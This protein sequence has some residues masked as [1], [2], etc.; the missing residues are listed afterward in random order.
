MKYKHLSKI[1]LLIVCSSVTIK[2]VSAEPKAPKANPYKEE[3][4]VRHSLFREKDSLERM[5]AYTEG[6][7]AY[8]EEKKTKEKM[9]DPE[10]LVARKIVD[11]Y[12]KM[13]DYLDVNP[14]DDQL[15]ADELSEAFKDFSWPKNDP[16]ANDDVEYAKTLIT[17]YDTESK[18]SI[19]FLEFC[20]LMEEMWGAADQIQES[21]CG[22]AFDKSRE[23]FDKLFTWLDRD[24]DNL[25]TP[26]DMIY[27]ISRI[28]IRDVDMKEVQ[29]V[30]AKYDTK[31]T[32]KIDKDTFF[33]AIANG[34]LDETFFD[35]TQTN[36]FIK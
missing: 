13:F 6:V 30:F 1:L 2:M 5:S 29:E 20:K 27:G 4:K 22:N 16:D 17:K 21:K 34:G 15:S 23:I 8:P 3:K 33:L 32:G 10:E 26:E 18:G 31:K 9:P 35:E 7:P 14:V 11:H 25:I 19:N 36:S 24:Q 12:R 28:M